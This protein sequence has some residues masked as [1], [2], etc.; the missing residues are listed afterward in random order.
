MSD[1]SAAPEPGRPSSGSIEAPAST[2]PSRTGYRLVG[3]VN[4]RRRVRTAYVPH[5]EVLLLVVPAPVWS[6]TVSMQRRVRTAYL[7]TCRCASY[8]GGWGGSPRPMLLTM[9][10]AEHVCSLA[11]W[12]RVGV[13]EGSGARRHFIIRGGSARSMIVR[14][15]AAPPCARAGAHRPLRPGPPCRS[16][17][18]KVLRGSAPRLIRRSSGQ[19][20]SRRRGSEGSRRA[21]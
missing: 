7:P 17:S 15:E 2:R 8:W 18:R 1:S 6:F 12:E 16:R 21:R 13:R 14:R 20:G 19:G 5:V 3:A 4:I 9:N 10:F 11:L